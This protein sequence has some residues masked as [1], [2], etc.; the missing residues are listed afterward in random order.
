MVC[1]GRLLRLRVCKT[2]SFNCVEGT[3][4][5]GNQQQGVFMDIGSGGHLED[6]I[7]NGGGV[8]LFTGNQQF[9][10]RNLT[11]NRCNTAIFQNWD[12]VYLYKSISINNCGTAVDMTQ[13]GAVLAMGSVVMQDSVLTN[14]YTASLPDSPMLA[15]PTLLVHSSW[16]MLRS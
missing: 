11:F 2:W 5:D 15:R 13:G 4:S 3:P 7:F 9:T 10:M 16:T 1:I 8:G 6:L 14:N 12:W